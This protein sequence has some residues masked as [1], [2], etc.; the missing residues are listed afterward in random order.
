MTESLSAERLQ[1]K[2]F[3]LFPAIFFGKESAL[4]SKFDFGKGK[5]KSFQKIRNE[6]YTGIQAILFQFLEAASRWLAF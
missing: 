1:R 4:L 3:L 6:T 2:D 5:G